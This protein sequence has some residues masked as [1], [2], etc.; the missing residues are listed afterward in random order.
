VPPPI[1][2]KILDMW[3]SIGDKYISPKDWRNMK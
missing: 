2:L 3:W 1:I